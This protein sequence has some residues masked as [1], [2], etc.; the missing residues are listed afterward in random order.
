MEHIPWFNFSYGAITGNDCD[1]EQSMKHLREWTLDC[2]EYN[3]QNS[4]RDDL[5]LEPGYTSYEGGLRAISPRETPVM[6]GSRNATVLDGGSNG[7]V[8]KEP[9]GFIRDYWMG[10]YYGFILAPS[11]NQPELISVK[12]SA[13]KQKGAKPYD[14]PGRPVFY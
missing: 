14:G 1:I 10:R 9:T 6:T 13:I 12:P 3:F 8:I 4:N 2:T 7:N 11:T 5:H